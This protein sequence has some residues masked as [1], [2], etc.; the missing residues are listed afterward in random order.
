MLKR[1]ASWVPYHILVRDQIQTGARYRIK[2]ELVFII[3]Q[4]VIIMFL[5]AGVGYVMFRCKKITKEGSTVIGN[6]LIY[7]S[8]PCVVLNGFL[9]ESTGENFKGLAISAALGL[10]TIVISGL[11]ARLVLGK[12]AI[13]NFAATFANPAFF[14][15]PLVIASFSREAVFYLAAYIAFTNLGQ[16][17]YGVYLLNREKKNGEK[18]ENILLKLIKAPFMVGIVIGLFFFLSGLKMPAI[19]AKCVTAL[20]DITTP[21]AMFTIGIYL[22]Q[23]DI[24]KLFTKLSLYKVAL[25]RMLL[26]PLVMLGILFLIPQDYFALK[27]TLLIG[28]ACPVGSNVA[29][30]A[31]LHDCDYPYAVETVIISTLVSIVTIPGIVAIANFIW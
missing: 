10:L 1:V 19:P 26:C 27:M 15:I 18:G 20:A 4:Q 16:W 5:L 6:I 17:T 31:Q 24:K 12:S 8:L 7:L 25:V 29:V 14:G 23:T 22:A 11:L 13:D 21:L 28:A 9:V 30:Y 3:I 2:M